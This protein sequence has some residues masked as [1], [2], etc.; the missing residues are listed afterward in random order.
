MNQAPT[1]SDEDLERLLASKLNRTSPEFEQRWRELRA[2]LI[3]Q[4]S[5]RQW[6]SS[7]RW[8]PWRGFATAAIV[9]LALVLAL[10]DFPRTPTVSDTSLHAELFSLDAALAPAAPLLDPEIRDAVIYLPASAKP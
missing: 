2:A 3:A 6:P 7:L 9:V 5:A 10:R 1:P 8:L 4:P